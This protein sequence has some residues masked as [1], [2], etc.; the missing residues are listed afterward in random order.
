MREANCWKDFL[1]PAFTILAGNDVESTNFYN[2]LLDIS[3][4]SM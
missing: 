4:S 1:N 3:C 2:Y